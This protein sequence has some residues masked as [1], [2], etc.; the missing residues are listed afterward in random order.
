MTVLRQAGTLEDTA[1]SMSPVLTTD[2]KAETSA[3]AEMPSPRHSLRHPQSWVC[4]TAVTPAEGQPVT[5]AE[6]LS[7]QHRGPTHL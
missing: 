3:L 1:T 7:K 4:D 2:K 5:P 6:R